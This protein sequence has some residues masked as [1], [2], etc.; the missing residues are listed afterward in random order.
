MSFTNVRRIA[1]TRPA[2]DYELYGIKGSDRYRM[3]KSQGTDRVA[4]MTCDM[5][6]PEAF[7]ERAEALREA[8]GRKIEAISLIQSFEDTEFNPNDPDSVARVNELGYKLAKELAD[9]SD[10]LVTTHV[11]GHGGMPHNHIKILNHVN[12]TGK[13]IQT[14][15]L[16]DKIALVND[17]LMVAENC[18][19]MERTRIKERQEKAMSDWSLARGDLPAFEQQLGDRIA[20][21]MAAVPDDDLTVSRFKDELATRGIELVEDRRIIKAAKDGSKDA[22]ESVGWTYKMQDTT[23]EKPRMRRRKAS[24]I[25]SAFTHDGVVAELDARQQALTTP[26]VPVA[27]QVAVKQQQAV[28]E[29]QEQAQEPVEVVPVLPEVEE[30]QGH[31]DG[32]ERP[33]EARQQSGAPEAAPGGWRPPEGLPQRREEAGLQSPAA[34]VEAKARTAREREAQAQVAGFEEAAG[35]ESKK[36]PLTRK[37]KMRADLRRREQEKARDGRDGGMGL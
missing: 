8:N 9:D 12:S 33:Q 17:R 25:N 22:H 19:V 3:H 11:D 16:H 5:D 20:E 10:A 34:G 29:E 14:R 36:A 32:Q 27:T 2:V 30:H 1:K 13:S 4:A 31:Q 6:S 28:I 24:S 37:E 18:R 23:G 35:V 21:S 7:V 15:M 26:K